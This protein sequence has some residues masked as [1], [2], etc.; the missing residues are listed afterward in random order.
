MQA[1]I[2][3]RKQGLEFPKNVSAAP[4][5]VRSH[6]GENLLCAGYLRHLF[7]KI[8]NLCQ[9]DRSRSVLKGFALHVAFRRSLVARPRGLP[10]LRPG[11]RLLMQ[12]PPLLQL[13]PVRGVNPIPAVTAP[14]GRRDIQAHHC[15]D[16][17]EDEEHLHLLL[18]PWACLTR[19]SFQER[20]PTTVHFC[21]LKASDTLQQAAHPVCTQELC[22]PH[23]SHLLL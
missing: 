16:Q 10:R 8:G 13:C 20:P 17:H 18:L 21:E 12:R 6:P 5:C 1:L 22:S 15:D 23:G 7:V 3:P 19:P 14:E 2:A 9:H 4:R 11:G